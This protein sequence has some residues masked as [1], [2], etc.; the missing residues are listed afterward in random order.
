MAWKSSS[1]LLLLFSLLS[2][3]APGPARAEPEPGK[4]HPL[5]SRMPNFVMVEYHSNYDEL[6]FP[7]PQ[8]K[9]RKAEGDKTLITYEI[10]EDAQPPSALQIARNYCNA[11]KEKGGRILF[12]GEHPDFGGR[13]ATIS[14]PRPGGEVLVLVE[15]WAH[16]AA[17]RLGIL[18]IGEM[19]QE[20]AGGDLR[21]DLERRGRVTLY[22]NFDTGKS[23]IR[24]ESQAVVGRVAEMMSQDPGL[25]ILVEGHTDD[26]GDP[27]SNL[28]LSIERAAKVAEALI[29]RGVSPERLAAGGF[30]QARPL[31]ANKDEAGRAKNRRVELVKM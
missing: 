28:R 15:S 12:D 6:S 9:L 14:L 19:R 27:Q 25:R 31:A 23:S 3:L 5:V 4:D 17:Y 22:I 11:L 13:V 29:Q 26:V 16:G 20:V 1:C 21:Q 7:L 30:G 24:P 10:K 8:D 18:E 2:W